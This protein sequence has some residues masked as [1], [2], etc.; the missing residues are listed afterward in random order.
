METIEESDENLAVDDGEELFFAVE[1][2]NKWYTAYICELLKLRNIEKFSLCISFS[3]CI[4]I[5][6]QK[7]TDLCEVLIFSCITFPTGS[8][9]LPM[10][11]SSVSLITVQS[12]AD[13]IKTLRELND[14]NGKI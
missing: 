3:L 6:L 2:V 5:P 1:E 14:S 11:R 9:V 13:L 7:S 12:L 10:N 4:F 8:V